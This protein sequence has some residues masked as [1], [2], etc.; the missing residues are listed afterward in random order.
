MRNVVVQG[1]AELSDFFVS[2]SNAILRPVVSNVEGNFILNEFGPWL[3]D[4][5]RHAVQG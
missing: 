5:A 4:A 2:V 3:F 1:V